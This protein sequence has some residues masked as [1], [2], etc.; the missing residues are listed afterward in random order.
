VLNTESTIMPNKI[1]TSAVLMDSVI[2]CNP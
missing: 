2:T 1:S